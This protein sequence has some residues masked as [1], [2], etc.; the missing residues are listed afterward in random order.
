MRGR[1]AAER[2]LAAGTHRRAIINIWTVLRG[3]ARLQGR[4]KYR[5]EAAPPAAA[6][7]EGHNWPRQR[8]RATAAAACAG[9]GRW[10][11]ECS[12][13]SSPLALPCCPSTPAFSACTAQSSPGRCESWATATCGACGC[14][15]PFRVFCGQRN[16]RAFIFSPPPTPTHRLLLR[17]DE[18]KRHKKASDKFVPT[19]LRE[20][21]HYA[22]TLEAQGGVVAGDLGVSLDPAA[23]ATLS[24]QQQDQLNKLKEE[25]RKLA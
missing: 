8:A 9:G 14:L 25:A 21:A 5:R 24:P 3:I 23:V 16:T 2:A 6:P 10:Y 12:P 11:L 4:A 20:W 7:S 13:R 15:P 22:A 17:R 18:F 19:F 1:A